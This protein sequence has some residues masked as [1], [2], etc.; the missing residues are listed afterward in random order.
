MLEKNGFKV[1]GFCGLRDYKGGKVK[2][3]GHPPGGQAPK[4]AAD[5]T[6]TWAPLRFL[7]GAWEG[8]SS[9]RPG[10]G[11]VRREYRL[12]LRD[13]FIEGR[14][15]STYPPQENNPKGEVHEDIAYLSYDRR[16]KAFKMRQFHVEG[17]VTEYVATGSGPA[18]IV[19]TSEN[20]ENIPAGW[21]ARETW[22]I[23]GAD[24]F[25]EIFELAEPGKDFTVYSETRL[26]RGNRSALEDTCVPA[27]ALPSTTQE[28]ETFACDSAIG[29]RR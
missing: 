5:T 26:I 23:T 4:A 13:R 3:P 19:F 28:S 22:R 6:D 7:L 25:V 10:N 12:V 21:R 14:A 18:E 15:T 17:F 2:S 9:G 24:S 20:L 11:T 8:T 27:A 29:Q 16:T 1:A